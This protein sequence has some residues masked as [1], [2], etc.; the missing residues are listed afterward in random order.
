MQGHE[1][2]TAEARMQQEA[3]AREVKELR[4][5]LG[6]AQDRQEQQGRLLAD[7]T[8]LAAAQK[9][10]LKVS[11]RLDLLAVCCRCVQPEHGLCKAR[12]VRVVHT[13]T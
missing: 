12:L 7:I 3:H 4:A 2:A 1:A 5:M 11:T 9:A 10:Q 13:R 8:N 6:A